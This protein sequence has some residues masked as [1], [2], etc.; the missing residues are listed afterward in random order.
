MAYLTERD[1]V[2]LSWV[3]EQ[4]AVTIDQLRVLMGR[5]ARGETKESGIVS[6]GTAE[7]RVKRWIELDVVEREKKFMN[8]PAWIWLTNEGLSLL[9]Q[10]Y[11][12]SRPKLVKLPE[13]E[14]VNDTRLFVEQWGVEQGKKVRWRSERRIRYDWGRDPSKKDRHVPDAEAIVDG[15]VVAIEVELTP[16]SDKRIQ[17][18]LKDLVKD[19]NS[20]W[21]FTNH[22]TYG[23][24]DR[25][26]KQLSQEQQE[27][28]RIYRL[29]E[30][31]QRD[32]L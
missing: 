16:K 25:K 5:D 27:Q 12:F 24:I 13:F 28:I 2:V 8:K 21:Y 6:V 22:Q 11:R 18:I 17:K 3:G 31:V 4:Y 32:S 20:I 23:F 29:E 9:P 19:Y 14:W 10:E 26:R 30:T 7:R 1:V 15:E